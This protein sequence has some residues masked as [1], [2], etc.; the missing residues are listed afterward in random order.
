MKLNM[1]KAYQSSI[2]QDKEDASFL[3]PILKSQFSK[4]KFVFSG[5]SISFSFH[6]IQFLINYD[7]MLVNVR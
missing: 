5:I 2:N 6:I 4:H 1:I 3:A 7:C